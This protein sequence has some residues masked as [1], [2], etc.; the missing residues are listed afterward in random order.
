MTDARRQLRF[1]QGQRARCRGTPM[2]TYW[3]GSVRR[4]ERRLALA[5]RSESAGLAHPRPRERRPGTARPRSRARRTRRAT[6]AGPD[7]GDPD[8][9]GHLDPRARRE[10]EGAA[11]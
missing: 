3:L 11:A 10:T 2:E 7:P 1:S 9:A 5:T 6:R 8:P 4:N